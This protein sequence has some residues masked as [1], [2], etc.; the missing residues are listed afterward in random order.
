M[1]QRH[2]GFSGGGIRGGGAFGRG[3]FNSGGFRGGFNGGGGMAFAEIDFA[4]ATS[5]TDS[6][7]L[8]ILATHSFTIPIRITDT[9]PTDII[10]TITDTV[11]TIRTINL[12]QPRQ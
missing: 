10:P 9:I 2:G 8:T 5:M 11:R 3:G 6:S 1:A 12:T 4:I 7:S